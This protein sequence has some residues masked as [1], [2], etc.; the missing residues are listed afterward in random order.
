LKVDGRMDLDSNDNENTLQQKI[1][2]P[3]VQD[4]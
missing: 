1:E 4:I 3:A 2:N